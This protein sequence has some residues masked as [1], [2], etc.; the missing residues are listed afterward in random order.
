M[1]V[2]VSGDVSSVLYA[3]RTE[4]NREVSKPKRKRR[5]VSKR[6]HNAARTKPERNTDNATGL[7]TRKHIAQRTKRRRKVAKRK[8]KTQAGFE[9]Q[10]TCKSENA[11]GVPTC[12]Q[13]AKNE[14]HT[15]ATT[16]QTPEA[17]NAKP[18]LQNAHNAAG[19]A[20]KTWITKPATQT[21]HIKYLSGE[22][23]NCNLN[24]MPTRPGPVISS[25]PVG[26]VLQW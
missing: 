8:R 9:A 15:S 4:H 7:S 24:V 11:I 25:G 22:T 1:R 16:T 13:H 12:N 18:Q 10:P 5:P 20:T 19:C 14:Q 6:N 26:Y 2:C 3:K 17:Q 21:Q 23:C